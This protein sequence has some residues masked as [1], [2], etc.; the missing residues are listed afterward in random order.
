MSHLN[1]S[2][3]T[4]LFHKT[5]L[6]NALKLNFHC[7]SICNNT[8]NQDLLNH[9]QNKINYFSNK[10]TRRAFHKNNLNNVS[11]TLKLIKLFSNQNATYTSHNE[12]VN[13]P[14][15]KNQAKKLEKMKKKLLEKEEKQRNQSQTQL[16]SESN[17]D[18]LLQKYN[19]IK[20]LLISP[21]S[22]NESHYKTEKIK[23]LN[24]TE[25]KSP[26]KVK[27]MGW[28]QHVRHHGRGKISFIELRDGTCFKNIQCVLQ[29]DL[30]L[31][32]FY[33]I[34]PEQSIELWG[35]LIENDKAPYGRE[36]Q[37]EFYRIVGD[38]K[39]LFAINQ[40]TKVDVSIKDR[41]LYIRESKRMAS[42]LKFRSLLLSSLRSYF[43]EKD[44][45]EVTPPTLVQTEVEGGSTLFKLDYFGENAYLTQSSQ[46]Y[47]ES[48]LPVLGDVFCIAQSYRAEK[49]QT[50]RHLAEYTHLEVERSFIDFEELLNSIEDMVQWVVKDV[51]SRGGDLLREI[52]PSAFEEKHYIQKI[53][54]Q[55]NNRI[56]FKRMTYHEC[57]QFCNDHDIFPEDSTKKFEIGDD[58]TDR[59]ERQMIEKIGEPVFMIKFPAEMKSFY[60]ERCKDDNSLTNSVDLLLPG[61]GEAVGG[62]MRIW[63]FEELENAFKREK[64]DPAPYYWYIDQRKFG[65]VPHGGYGLG[66]E[67]L[68]MWLLGLPHIREACLYP[69][70]MGRC[71]P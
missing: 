8:T 1:T 5:N 57:I 39:G 36:I 59:P 55:T 18:L 23:N 3:F 49:S 65:S 44:H 71:S 48:V 41:H 43:A 64:I 61:V 12:D 38:V 42:I 70:Y 2:T 68:L 35:S 30:S 11:N 24:F 9:K 60:M 16:Q 31:R 4:T 17:F 15:S 32:A 7:I 47:L 37:I 6:C 25:D 19:E 33:E 29:N 40:D 10:L 21:Q 46:L 50:P 34:K 28:V 45:F 52:N 53:L 69:R 63:D 27:V 54:K 51:V 66:V 14:L 13:A 58:I 67:R 20:D 56:P 22:Q 62:S 26:R